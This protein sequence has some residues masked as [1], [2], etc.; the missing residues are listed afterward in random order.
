M[1]LFVFGRGDEARRGLGLINR[2][3]WTFA[4]RG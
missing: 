1:H 4:P 2:A 3:T